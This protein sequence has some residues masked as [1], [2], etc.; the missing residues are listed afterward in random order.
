MPVSL[1]IDPEKRLV[2]SA[3]HG[4]VNE[5]EF[6]SHRELIRSHPQFDPSYAEV[7]DFCGLT[8]MKVSRDTLRQLATGESLY[9]RDAHHVVI[10]PPGFIA[11]LAKDYRRL[12]EETRPNF[13]V[14]KSRSEAYDHLRQLRSV[15]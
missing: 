9:S 12:S 3:F 4:D 2:Y 14:V 8:D 15:V 10:A 11:E 7:L 13:V 5:E 6:L 1:S